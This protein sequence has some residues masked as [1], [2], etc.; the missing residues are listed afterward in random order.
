MLDRYID[1]R[2]SYAELLYN[3]KALLFSKENNIFG[4]SVNVN[5]YD[6]FVDYKTS[7]TILL[8]AFYVI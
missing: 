2:Y 7:R 3:P 4:F 6:S 5:S 8:M 1:P